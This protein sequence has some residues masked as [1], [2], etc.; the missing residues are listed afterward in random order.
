MNDGVP[1]DAR[2]RVERMLEGAR[3]GRVE[4]SEVM[5]ELKR[6]DLFEEYEDRFLALFRT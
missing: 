5:R 6:W 4:P 3:Q 2:R 1:A